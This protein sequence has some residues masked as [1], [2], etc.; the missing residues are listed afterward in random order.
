MRQKL[1]ETLIGKKTSEGKDIQSV[2]QHAVQRTRE[3]G[4]TPNQ[5]LQA[6][7]KPERI[8]AGNQGNRMCYFNGRTK[9]VFDNNRN[10]II[11]VI[12]LKKTKGEQDGVARTNN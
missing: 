10:E 7:Q 8:E 11:T 3:R 1:E 6:L 4:R 12:R 5:I 9:V 2:S